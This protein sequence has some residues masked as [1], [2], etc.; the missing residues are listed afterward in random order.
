[1]LH[2]LP[3]DALDDDI[4]PSRGE[5]CCLGIAC[6]VAIA[7]GVELERTHDGEVPRVFYRERVTFSGDAEVLPLLV[8]QWFG[9]MERDPHL[10]IPMKV[11]EQLDDSHKVHRTQLDRVFVASVLNDDFFLDFEQ[12]ADCFEYTFLREDWDA[13][14]QG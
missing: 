10:L 6:E 1:M 4:D 7:G 13:R 8:Q 14:E 11:R 9:L 3:E 12:I 2:R 5:Y